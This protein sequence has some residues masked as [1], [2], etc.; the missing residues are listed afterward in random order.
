MTAWQKVRNV[1]QPSFRRKPES[2]YFEWLQ[3]H[4]TPVPVPDSDPGFTGVT[5]FDEVVK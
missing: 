1:R 2:R 3:K 5:T 4:W